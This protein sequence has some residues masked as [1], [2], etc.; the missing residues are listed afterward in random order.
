MQSVQEREPSSTLATA[1]QML[2]KRRRLRSKLPMTFPIKKD[3]D[4]FSW[5]SLLLDSRIGYSAIPQVFSLTSLN[6]HSI[7][8]TNSFK[9]L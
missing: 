2:S 3:S 7:S 6:V 9:L 8:W 5:T 4:R 1:V